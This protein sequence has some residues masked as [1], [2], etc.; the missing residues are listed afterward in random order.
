MLS[1]EDLAQIRRRCDAAAPG[2]WKAEKGDPQWGSIGYEVLGVEKGDCNCPDSDIPAMLADEEDAIFIAHAR[3]DVP[4]LL[5]EVERLRNI[6]SDIAA[7][8]ADHDGMTTV[9][10][11]CSVI[12]DLAWLARSAVNGDPVYVS[13]GAKADV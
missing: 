5:A 10:G 3:E 1:A 11:L 13:E 9:Q 2:P 4:R 8:A 6:M 12:D 7:I